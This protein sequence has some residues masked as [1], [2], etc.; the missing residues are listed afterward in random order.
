MVVAVLM[1]AT[2]GCGGDDGVAS[3]NNDN[4]DS[5]QGTQLERATAMAECLQ[6]AGVEVEARIDQDGKQA[7]LDFGSK[8][9]WSIALGTGGYGTSW[10]MDHETN[11]QA[12]EDN[13]NS[14][15]D[16]YSSDSSPVFLIIG[17]QDHTAAFRECLANTG[18]T[19]PDWSMTPAQEL[20]EKEQRLE[21]ITNWIK[22]A[23]DNGYPDL[24]DPPT[25]KADNWDT[26]PMALLPR[27]TT[28]TELRALLKACPNFNEQDTKAGLDELN[29]AGYNDLP[30][31]QARE[32]WDEMVAK[33]PGLVSPSIGF[34]RAEFDGGLA[35]SRGEGISQDQAEYERLTKL[36]DIIGQAEQDFL[37]NYYSQ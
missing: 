6:A 13:M 28:E 36:V 7:D 23:R 15:T 21:A 32:L 2:A 1:V 25:P 27:V 14:M 12:T 22:C 18:Y 30:T 5:G 17:D 37:T 33:Y 35:F 24:Q 9:S 34:D 8:R 10:G 4:P 3:L 19:E 26:Q 31:A 20:Q 29:A 11:Q 16:E